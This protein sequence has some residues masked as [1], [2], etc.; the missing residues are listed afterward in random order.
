MFL[1]K[2]EKCNKKINKHEAK[3]G[4]AKRRYLFA[5]A[6]CITL[7]SADLKYFKLKTKPLKVKN[8]QT[9]Q[10]PFIK[11]FSGVFANNISSE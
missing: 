1:N 4:I 10:P 7:V 2:P 5:M 11:M 9:A 8:I 6:P 3:I